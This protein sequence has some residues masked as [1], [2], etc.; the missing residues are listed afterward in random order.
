MIFRLSNWHGSNVSKMWSLMHSMLWVYACKIG[1]KDLAHAGL[2]VELV[3][4]EVGCLG[5]FLPSSVTNMCRVCHLSK[6]STR[7]IFKQA[8][9]VAIF[10]LLS[11]F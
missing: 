10:M 5:Q 11:N 6:H 1:N 4:I 7:C 3:T 2:S 9:G 8:A